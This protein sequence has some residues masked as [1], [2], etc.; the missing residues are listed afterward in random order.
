VEKEAKAQIEHLSLTAQ[1][2]VIANGLES[3]AAKSFL[4]KMPSLEKLMPS[5]NAVEFERMMNTK[6]EPRLRVIN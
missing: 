4:D 6:A 5:I 2:E 3:D 1:T